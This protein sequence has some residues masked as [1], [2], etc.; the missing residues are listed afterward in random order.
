MTARK[1]DVT[2]TKPRR[3]PATTPQERE[4]RLVNLAL[5]LV[6][7]QLEE[8]TASAQV[9]SLYARAASSRERL[10]QEKLKME[11]EL[12][13]A[14]REMMASAARV[15]ELYTEAIKAM[16]AYAGQEPLELEMPVE[17][18]YYED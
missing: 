9:I 12:L 11:T 5:D 10:E 3:P 15:E 17:D 8:G 14:K 4:D 13:E 6:E 7:R 1:T 2:D 16:R 18:D